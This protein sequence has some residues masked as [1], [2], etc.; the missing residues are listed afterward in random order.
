MIAKAEGRLL[1]VCLT[2]VEN[3]KDVDGTFGSMKTDTIIANAETILGRINSLKPLH[4][5]RTRHSKALNGDLHA[6]CNDLVQ[7]CQIG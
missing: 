2:A 6:A 7:R 4:I 5:A 1:A 3:A